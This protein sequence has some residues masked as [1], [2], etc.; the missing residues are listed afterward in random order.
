MKIETNIK[1]WEAYVPPRCRKERYREV[2]KTINTTIPEAKYTDAPIAMRMQGCLREDAADSSGAY[3]NGITA[4]IKEVDGLQ[5]SEMWVDYRLY[6]N[7]LY[8]RVLAHEK[9]CGAKGPWTLGELIKRYS[10]Y[11]HWHA[12]ADCAMT[13]K[14]VRGELHNFLL[15]D[16]DVWVKTGEPV[17][18]IA[19]FG[20]GHNHAS[21]ALMNDT[22]YR[23]YQRRE[24][25]NA[26]QRDEAIAECKRVAMAR[27]DTNSIPRIGEFWKIEVLIPE[28]VKA[29]AHA[30]A[31]GDD[32]V[33]QA[34]AIIRK[35]DS[36][37]EAGLLVMCAALGG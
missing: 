26:L 31:A 17:Y 23:G 15:L 29:P 28:A 33:G 37:F 4:I 21:T 1:F 32:F 24:Y 7:R 12:S 8:R 25:F 35:S 10:T 9:Y 11:K 5:D 16:G 20:L 30:P 34:E 22:Y 14:A 36:A 19:T 2:T 13:A 3:P 18:T 27:G 6:K